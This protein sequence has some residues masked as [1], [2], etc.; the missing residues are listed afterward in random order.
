[1]DKNNLIDFYIVGK[2]IRER[3][4]IVSTFNVTSKGW[5]QQSIFDDKSYDFKYESDE[6]I[7]DILNWLKCDFTQSRMFNSLSEA[8]AYASVKNEASILR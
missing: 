1:M 6:T 7:P 4:F 3:K 5:L 2:T 8:Q